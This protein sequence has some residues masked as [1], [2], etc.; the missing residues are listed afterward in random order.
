MKPDEQLELWVQ[1]K[2]V[3]NDERD[4][5]CPDFSCCGGKLADEDT[6][7]RFAKAFYEHDENTTMNMLMI[8]LGDMLKK[9]EGKK[10]YVAGDKP[11]IEQMRLV[12]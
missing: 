6:R 2:S 10:I 7:K 11:S 8:F 1:G 3:H 9:I 12:N 4:E 5:C